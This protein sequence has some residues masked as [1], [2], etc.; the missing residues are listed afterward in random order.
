M[1]K[2]LVAH[3]VPAGAGRLGSGVGG[4]GLRVENGDRLGQGL[5]DRCI[6]PNCG[7]PTGMG[8]LT[9]GESWNAHPSD[10]PKLQDP[11]VV[12]A[13]EDRRIRAMTETHAAPH[14]IDG[15]L[16]MLFHPLVEP[17]RLN[18]SDYSIFK[19]EM[20]NRWG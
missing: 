7:N 8:P 18:K 19:C 11:Q 4:E 17:I 15:F 2:A 9:G 20:G 14:F 6:F 16:F 13:F 12:G 3:R 10:F 5:A 1:E